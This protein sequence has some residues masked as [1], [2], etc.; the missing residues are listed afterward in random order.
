MS[1]RGDARSGMN[2]S[3]Y[4]PAGG[5][6]AMNPRHT[7]NVRPFAAGCREPV[8]QRARTVGPSLDVLER[9]LGDAGVIPRSRGGIAPP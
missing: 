9:S 2:S 1:N 7:P 3:R 8:L 5:D 6:R 4:P